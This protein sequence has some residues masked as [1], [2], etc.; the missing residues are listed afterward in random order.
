VIGLTFN[1]NFGRHLPIAIG[2]VFV[3]VLSCAAARADVVI[4]G[5]KDAMTVEAHASSVA[6]ILDALG[7]S[8]GLHYKAAADLEVTVSRTFRGSLDQVLATLLDR[9]NYVA[10]ATPSGDIDLVWIRLKAGSAA[11]VQIT[12]APSDPNELEI[13]PDI[14]RRLRAANA[15][16]KNAH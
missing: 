16:M 10:K 14:R 8:F 4:E 6:E 3:A 11:P 9:Y 1:Q 12:A 2:S 15:A 7:K 13:T 5:S